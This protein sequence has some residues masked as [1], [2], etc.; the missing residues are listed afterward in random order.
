MHQKAGEENLFNPKSTQCFKDFGQMKV[1]LHCHLN[2]TILEFISSSSM[3]SKINCSTRSQSGCF[4]LHQ[5]VNSV[6]THAQMNHN[7]GVN[8]AVYTEMFLGETQ[9]FIC[10]LAVLLHENSVCLSRKWNNTKVG[11]TA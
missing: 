4:A 3:G 6:F 11:S 1:R 10:V 5:S 7:K 8:W 2:Q 9:N